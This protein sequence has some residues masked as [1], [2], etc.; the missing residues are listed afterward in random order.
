MRLISFLIRY[1]RGAVLL[2][3]GAGVVS[4]VCNMGLLV[5]INSALKSGQSS[6]LAWAFF[7][8]CLALPLSRFASEVLLTRLGQGALFDLRLRLSRQI[9]AAPLRHLEELGAH[10]LLAT[11]T[12]DVPVIT[13]AV[14]AIPVLCINVAVAVA[15]LCYLGWLSWPLLIV[16]LVFMAVGIATYQI[17]LIR[18][19]RLLRLAREESDALLNHFRALIGGNKELKLHSRRQEVF[20]SKVLRNTALSFRRHNVAGMNTYSAAASWGQVLVFIA[21]GLTIFALPA[22]RQL[23]A[24]TLLGYVLTLLYMMT[25]MQL[26][27]NTVP[28]L[29]RAN[30]ALRKIETLGLSLAEHATEPSAAEAPD[31]PAKTL[32]RLELRGVTHTYRHDGEERS[33]V[34]G[35]IDLTLHPGRLLFFAGGN[36]SGKTTLAKLIAGLYAPERGEIRLDGEAITDENR[37]QYRQNFSAV[38]SDFY[39]FES[40]LGLESPRLDE[41]ARDYLSRLQLAHKVGVKDGALSTTELSQGQRKRLALLTAYLEDRPIYIFD[42]WAADQDPLFKS[43][44]YLQLLPELRARGKVVVVISHDDQYY[45]VADELVKLTYGQIE[46]E[47]QGEHTSSA[48]RPLAV[49]FQR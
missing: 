35:P 21:V 24:Q 48:V 23:E 42:E 12:E 40:L 31:E 36:G 39:L 25:P 44:F 27:M 16:V 33:F 22:L 11:L 45:G 41:H 49:P 30:V 19:V 8:L 38:F 29:S 5:V 26:I 4:G 34:L 46:G 7:A 28:T 9:V 3:V 10:R 13:N 6:G 20:L 18:A 2:A 37:A 32:R 1:S 15:G 17:P 43:V 14:L 47:P